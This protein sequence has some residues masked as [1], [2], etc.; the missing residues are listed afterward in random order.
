MRQTCAIRPSG[1]ASRQMLSSRR[2]DRRVTISA[3]AL[4]STAR[5]STASET[6]ADIGRPSPVEA[7]AWCGAVRRPRA[8]AP[9][10]RRSSTPMSDRA[11]RA[12]KPDE[13]QTQKTKGHGRSSCPAAAPRASLQLTAPGRLL[14]PPQEG[15]RAFLCSAPAVTSSARQG[16]AGREHAPGTT[17]PTSS[18]SIREFTPK[19]DSCR[20]S[21]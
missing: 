1:P 20:N 8:V 17:R 18:A 7:W 16:G 13:D 21:M 6:A 3:L 4:A 9:A 10:V 12:S 5:L 14:A 19:C 15:P 2:E 11:R